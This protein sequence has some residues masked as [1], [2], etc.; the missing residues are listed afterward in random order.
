MVTLNAR[1]REPF[2]CTPEPVAPDDLWVTP[3]SNK[4]SVSGL[5]PFN[6]KVSI[7]FC[8]TTFPIVALE[9][10]NCSCLPMTVTVSE[11]CP[12]SKARSTARGVPTSR[13]LPVF[14]NVLKPCFST[15]IVYLPTGNDENANRPESVVVCVLD[16]PVASFFAVTLAPGTT[17]PLTSRTMPV[18]F[19][20][21]VC[22]SA[23]TAQIKSNSA[24][25]KDLLGVNI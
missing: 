13:T 1:S 12:I 19:D 15:L 14:C 9:F 4:S 17:A 22:D 23:A 7:A 2:T 16:T 5:R 3:G 25:T 10:C 6:G 21:P 18:M 11:T 8:S 24:D 20:V